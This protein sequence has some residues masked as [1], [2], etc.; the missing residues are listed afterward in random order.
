MGRADTKSTFTD[1]WE[2]RVTIGRFMEA[3]DDIGYQEAS[4]VVLSGLASLPKTGTEQVNV[5]NKVKTTV[6][7]DIFGNPRLLICSGVIFVARIIE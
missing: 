7:I 4:I 1:G 3:G 6:L 5:T 2:D